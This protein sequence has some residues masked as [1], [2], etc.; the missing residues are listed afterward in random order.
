MRDKITPRSEDY[1][2]W[3]TEVIR[4]AEL[5][6]YAPVRGCMVIRPYGYELWENVKAGLDRR[7]KETGHENAYFPLFVP[8]SFIEKEAQHVEGF[9]PELAVVTHGGGKELEDPLVVRPTSETV[10]GYMYSQWIQSYRDLPVLINQWANV[11]RW[12]LRT[13]LFLRTMEF[14]WQEGHTAHA[15]AE[16]AQE[17]TLRM[18]DVYADFAVNDAAIPVIPGRKSESEKFP[19]A[20][21]SY[22]IEA[23][24]GDCRALQSGTSHNLGQNFAKA[25]DIQY[26]DGNGKQQYCWTTS[27][28]VSTRMVGAIIMAHGD[29]QGLVLPPRLAPTQ[30]VV[31]PI[32]RKDDERSTVMEAIEK[33]EAMLGPDVRLKVDNRDEYSPGWKFNEWELK[34]VPLRIE[35]GPRDIAKDQVVLARRDVPGRDGKSFVPL[36]GLGDVVSDTLNDI[37]NDLLARA[38]EFRDANTSEPS[39]YDSLREAAVQGFA[40]AWWCGD[41]A[42]EDKVKNDI[43][44]TTRCIPSDQ[45]GGGGACIVCGKP[46]EEIAIFARAY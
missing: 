29:D 45:P 34:G 11:V 23:M 15:T 46:A 8:M 27:W 32:Y 43:K 14:L 40:R 25:F 16:E 17:E 30:V 7:F 44:A 13:R 9:A 41:I 1:S 3:Y 38:T 37:Q 22:S 31:V 12:E 18:L 5:A 26:Q 20:D 21:A 39:D 42:C 4:E 24:M 2:E 35:I 19:G 28:G 10:I 33:I 6:D 36:V